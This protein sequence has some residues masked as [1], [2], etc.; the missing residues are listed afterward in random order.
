MDDT[1]YLGHRTLR[2]VL[3]MRET[4]TSMEE[5]K[6]L[7]EHEKQTNKRNYG[8]YTICLSTIFI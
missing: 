3:E 8:Q 6:C 7:T 1:Y 2:K 4:R 5:N